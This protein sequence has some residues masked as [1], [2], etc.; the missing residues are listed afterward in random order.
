MRWSA[1]VWP[2]HEALFVGDH[3][4]ADA[5]PDD[6]QRSRDAIAK[7]LRRG[8]RLK[9]FRGINGRSPQGPE[10]MASGVRVPAIYSTLP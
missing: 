8:R 7:L 6:V 9:G 5:C 2:P 3:P 4:V 10:F 1:A